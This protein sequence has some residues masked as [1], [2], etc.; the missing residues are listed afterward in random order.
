MCVFHVED[1]VAMSTAVPAPPGR[2]EANK[3]DKLARIRQAAREIFLRDGFEA[4]TA[5]DIAIAASVAFGTLF[6]YAKDKNELLLLVFDD[7]LDPLTERATQKIDRTMPLVDQLLSFFKEFYRFFCKTPELSR[8]MMRGMTFTG[9][10]VA[11]RTREG[12]QKTENRLAEIVAAAQRDGAI[13]AGVSPELAAHIFFSLYRME[14]RFCLAADRPD[15]KGSL[16]K[17]RQQFEIV[18]AGLQQP[19]KPPRGIGKALRA[20]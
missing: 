14:I 17:L 1:S 6:L 9:G 4:A 13:A 7:E 19:A 18:Y 10:I 11:T 16:G 15:T 5:R 2:R 12:V 3:R 8:Q 20:R